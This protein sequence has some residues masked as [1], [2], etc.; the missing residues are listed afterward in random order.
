MCGIAG[1]VA[2][3]GFNPRILVNMT[4]LIGYRGPD[5][6]GFAFFPPQK[7]GPAEIFHNAASVPK[8]QNPI[9]GLGNRRLAILDLSSL[10]N[11]PMQTE[12][13]S[14]TIV[15]NGE[16]Y[17][18]LTLAYYRKKD[19]QSAR[20]FARTAKDCG[21]DISPQLQGYLESGDQGPLP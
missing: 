12:D 17:N 5:G 10:G 3:D 14:L 21:Y 9:L 19:L 2:L 1:I 20:Y 11:Q 8:I 15:F 18:N 4:Q 7:R 13:G 16:I 6:F